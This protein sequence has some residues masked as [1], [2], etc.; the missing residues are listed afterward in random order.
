MYSETNLMPYIFAGWQKE[1]KLRFTFG[2]IT[3]LILRILP[4]INDE[5]FLQEL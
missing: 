5:I 2:A 1:N 4:R 3:K